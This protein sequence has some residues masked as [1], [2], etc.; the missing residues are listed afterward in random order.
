MCSAALHLHVRVEVLHRA[1]AAI[2]PI[3]PRRSEASTSVGH[4]EEHIVET[5]SVAPD[6]GLPFHFRV[7]CSVYPFTKRPENHRKVPSFLSD[8]HPCFIGLLQ[9]PED[10]I[11][12]NLQIVLRA[13]LEIHPLV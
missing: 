5:R 13:A 1:V 3:F 6:F 9:P 12:I 2:I 4:R 7:L 8:F 10:R 11:W